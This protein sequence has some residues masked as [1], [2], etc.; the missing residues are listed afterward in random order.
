MNVSECNICHE[1]GPVLN[2][3]PVIS[4]S[5]PSSTINIIITTSILY[6]MQREYFVALGKDRLN[7]QIYSKTTRYYVM[8]NSRF[9]HLMHGDTA[10]QLFH[11]NRGPWPEIIHL[12][13]NE[14]LRALSVKAMYLCLILLALVWKY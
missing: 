7:Y 5:V 6:T 10:I 9:L 12:M 8:E 11:T 13:L 2:I 1:Y 3:V 14:F 4:V